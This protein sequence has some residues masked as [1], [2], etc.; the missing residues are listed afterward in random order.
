[1][2][3]GRLQ[4]FNNWS[5]WHGGRPDKVWIGLEYFCNETDRFGSLRDDEIARFAIGKWK[6]SA[7]SKPRR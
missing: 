7:F 6:R 2:Q 3:V 1:M 5:P 4:I